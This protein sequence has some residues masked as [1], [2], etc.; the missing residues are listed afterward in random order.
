VRPMPILHFALDYA[1]RGFPVFPCNPANKR[2]L[3]GA[4]VDPATGKKIEGTGGFKKA[5]R[6]PQQITAWWEMWPDAMIGIPMGAQSG[7]WAIDPDAP[8]P[9]SNIDGRQNWAE[10]K[11]KN[12]GH[13][14]THTHDTPGGGQH[15]LFRYHPEKPV[16]NREGGLAGLGINVRGEGGYIIAPPSMAASGKRYEDA[17]PLYVFIFAEAP[18]WLYAQILTKPSISEQAA[19]RVQQPTHRSNSVVS[20]RRYAEAALRGERDTLASTMNGGRNNRLNTAAFKLGTL[21]A[22]GA[23]SERE[24]AET[25][26]DAAKTNGLVDDDGLRA[27][28]ATISSGMNAGLQSP[29]QIPAPKAKATLD[30]DNPVATNAVSPVEIFWHGIDY[31]RELRPWLVK[32]L[33]PQVGQGLASG[34]WGSG[35]TFAA[36]DLAASVMT[37]SPFAGREVCRRG[38]VLFIAA[39]GANEIAIRLQGVVDQKLRTSAPADGVPQT[40]DLNRLPFAWIEDCPSLRDEPSFDRLVAT[41]VTAASQIKEQFGI[42]LALIIVDTLSAAADFND[43][44]DAAEGQRIMG[45]LNSLSKT[46]G[47]FVLAVDHF[48]KVVETGT[49]GTSA[50]EAAADVVLALLADRDTAGKIS[51]TRLAVRKLRGGATG[52]ETPFDLR[53][54]DLGA[55][56]ETTCVIEWKSDLSTK[57]GP[58]SSR[59]RWPKKLRIFRQAMLTTLIDAGQFAHPF[60]DGPKVKMVPADKVKAEFMAAYPADGKDA[61]RIAF[62]RALRAARDA[63][64]ICSRDIGGID[65]LWLVDDE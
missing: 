9:P 20:H 62:N 21:V 59:Q 8:K 32:E 19:A 2:P 47:A 37:A 53:V 65:H 42:D 30:N 10:L 31:H 36:I 16:T 60:Y 3:P 51:N 54:V 40:F 38:G 52:A 56:G 55:A 13:A 41:A 43:A 22:A 6:D 61:K 5:S 24:V 28:V 57:Q 29:R 58:T 34:Q 25:L 23:L 39:E 7:V 44:N 46:T 17:K 11:R 33:I 27:A 12:G 49:R 63:E 18:D 14:H 64:L 50:K 15:I 35:K 1:R 26:V 48:G 45:R 4:D